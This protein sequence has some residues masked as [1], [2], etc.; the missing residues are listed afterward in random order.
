MKGGLTLELIDLL[1]GH[2]HGEPVSDML[3]PIE[4]HILGFLLAVQRKKSKKVLETKTCM[5]TGH[6]P[7]GKPLGCERCHSSLIPRIDSGLTGACPH[8]SNLDPRGFPQGI[9]NF[10]K[11]KNCM[12][13]S[14]VFT[15]DP[16]FD[17]LL[18]V[19]SMISTA[20]LTG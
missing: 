5:R 7:S 18:S 3:V 9:N 1:W 16:P 6:W 19:L 14:L 17:M 8:I 13:L 12:I 4:Q 11:T 2:F 10:K 15:H 20:A